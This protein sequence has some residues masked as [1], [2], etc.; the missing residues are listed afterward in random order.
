MDIN[1]DGKI[2][3][4]EFRGRPE[5]FKLFDS[6]GD[7]FANRSEI[8]AF[9]KGRTGKRKKRD[10]DALAGDSNGFPSGTATHADLDTVTKGAFLRNRDREHEKERGLFE[11]GLVPVYPKNTYCPPIDH[12]F[13]EPWRGPVPNRR[14][15]GADIPVPGGTPILAMAD[16]IVVA[17]F[18]G[19]QGYRGIE[20]VLQHPPEDTGLG[21][22]IYTQYAHLK[23]MPTLEIGQ[24]VQMGQVIGIT[25]RTGIPNPRRKEHLHLGTFFSQSDKYCIL[26][27]GVLVPVEGHYMDPVA[28]MRRQLP[29]DSHSMKALPRKQKYVTIPYKLTTGE[30]FPRNTKIIWP[31]ACKPK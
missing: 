27:R 21:V 9:F 10:D 13:G 22:W 30:I 8:Q 17:K 2:S 31:Y 20:I 19:E 14:H 3:R 18:R 23:K 15:H 11:T 12:I 6:D 28:L 4:Q 25:G 16:G 5:R 24:R 1:G 29:L 26:R 7:G